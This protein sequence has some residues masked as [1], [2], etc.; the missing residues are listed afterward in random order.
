[1]Y[2]LEVDELK[3]ELDV[4]VSQI[5]DLEKKELEKGL[6]VEDINSQNKLRF[7][8]MEIKQKLS[9]KGINI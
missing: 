8:Y 7:W 5:E 2:D 4:I 1:M 9:R 3:A 6:T